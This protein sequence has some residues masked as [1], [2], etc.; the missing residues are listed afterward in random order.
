MRSGI[1]VNQLRKSFLP[2]GQTAAGERNEQRMLAQ[3]SPPGL[4]KG[5][6]LAHH[7]VLDS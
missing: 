3:G 5:S 2:Q 4:R 6:S 1:L 7:P